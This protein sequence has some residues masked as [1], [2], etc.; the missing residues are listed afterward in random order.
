MRQVFRGDD[1]GEKERG[2][3]GSSTRDKL[4]YCTGYLYVLNKDL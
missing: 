2:V 1:E 3:G 4:M